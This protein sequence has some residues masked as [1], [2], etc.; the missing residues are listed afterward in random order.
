MSGK[1]SRTLD[2]NITINPCGEER[3]VIGICH[4]MR[5]RTASG[6]RPMPLGGVGMMGPDRCSGYGQRST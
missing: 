1:K 4:R 6:E 3:K 2:T 5:W